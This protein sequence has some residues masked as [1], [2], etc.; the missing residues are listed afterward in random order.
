MKKR[1]LLFIIIIIS[2]IA[3]Q[4]DIEIPQ[5]IDEA[6]VGYYENIENQ[7]ESGLK[8]K[9]DGTYELY[10][11]EYFLHNYYGEWEINNDKITLYQGIDLDTFVSVKAKKSISY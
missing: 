1:L 6:L 10:Q 5:E 4:R 7:I 8:L 2:V 11:I 3:C 9:K